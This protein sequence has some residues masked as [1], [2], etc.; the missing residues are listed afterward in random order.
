MLI[1]LAPKTRCDDAM[2]IRQDDMSQSS[3]TFKGR[4][5]LAML[6]SVMRREME[7]VG[8][9]ARLSHGPRTQIDVALGHVTENLVKVCEANGSLQLREAAAIGARQFKDLI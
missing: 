5:H 9:M 6:G 4:L 7:H 8:L 1:D 3:L 2:R